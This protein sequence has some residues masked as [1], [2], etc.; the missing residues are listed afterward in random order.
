MSNPLREEESRL[1]DANREE[2]GA[3]GKVRCPDLWSCTEQ[4]TVGRMYCS[5]V[6]KGM[7]KDVLPSVGL[8]ND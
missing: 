8:C 1:K 3:Y 5:G 4:V 6:R 2:D 7:R